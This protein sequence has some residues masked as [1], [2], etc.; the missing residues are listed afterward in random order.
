MVN[1]DIN[2]TL[3]LRPT[4]ETEI[5]KC[6]TQLKN[7]KAVGKDGIKAE[8]IKLIVDYVVNPI[9]FV[10]N[11]ILESGIYPDKFKIAVINPLF[12]HRDKTAIENYRPPKR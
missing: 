1:A 5:K 7:K 12:K 2:Y 11:N 8:T 6:I 4:D 9:C 3:F 10:F